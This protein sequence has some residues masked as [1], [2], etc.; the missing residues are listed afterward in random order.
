MEQ[1]WLSLQQGIHLCLLQ[2]YRFQVSSR[3]VAAELIWV[4]LL[5]GISKETAE[6]GSNSMF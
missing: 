2:D 3:H 1:R 4:K 5:A 6:M